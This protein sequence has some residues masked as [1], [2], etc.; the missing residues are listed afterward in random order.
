MFENYLLISNMKTDF[1]FFDLPP[2][3]ALWFLTKKKKTNVFTVKKTPILN[4][5]LNRTIY[6]ALL[7]CNAPKNKT[8]DWAAL[9]NT[10]VESGCTWTAQVQVVDKL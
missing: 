2:N 10:L 5:L 3:F 9:V 8:K 7:L 4:N 1:Q 6:Y